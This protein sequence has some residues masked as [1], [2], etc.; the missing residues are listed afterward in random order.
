[1]LVYAW[2]KGILLFTWYEKGWRADWGGIHNG[3]LEHTHWR[4]STV[5]TIAIVLL[6]IQWCHHP[7]LPWASYRVSD[8]HPW[9]HFS[10]QFWKNYNPWM[11][12]NT[13]ALFQNWC[14]AYGDS[15]LCQCKDSQ[16]AGKLIVIFLFGWILKLH[17]TYLLQ[18]NVFN[19]TL[20]QT[21][22]IPRW[23]MKLEKYWL[24]N[25]YSW[26]AVCFSFFLNSIY[27]K[28]LLWLLVILM[29]ENA[30]KKSW[31]HTFEQ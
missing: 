21:P 13:N 3:T 28:S 11:N 16:S 20:Q 23:Q 29:Q 26:A 15:M 30:C 22:I 2:I 19:N 27:F 17:H 25:K 5:E 12:T 10:S 4:N 31:S 24:W 8:Q 6:S 1:M 7:A 9:L 18:K 14:A